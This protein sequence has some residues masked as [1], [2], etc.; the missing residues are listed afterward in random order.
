[1][2]SRSES[3]HFSKIGQ[4]L[5]KMFYPDRKFTLSFELFPP[6]T[7]VLLFEPPHAVRN[8]I[9]RAAQTPKSQCL[10]IHISQVSSCLSCGHF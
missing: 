4:P 6:K 8:K 10:V 2:L 1:V 5:A 7:P 3:R 9:L